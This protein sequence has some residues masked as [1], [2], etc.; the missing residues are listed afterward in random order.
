MSAD[1]DNRM[2]HFRTLTRDACI[3]MRARPGFQ[4]SRRGNPFETVAQPFE[5]GLEGPLAA[6]TR[7][8]M[9]ARHL[10]AADRPSPPSVVTV[11]V[12]S[13]SRHRISAVAKRDRRQA[14]AHRDLTVTSPKERGSPP[15]TFS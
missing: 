9:L 5:G 2:H 3:R 1:A 15:L 14:T 12:T 11:T 6:S 8:Q 4:N 7:S 13:P 10:T